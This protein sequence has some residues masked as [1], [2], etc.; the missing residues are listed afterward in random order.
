MDLSKWTE[1]FS[2]FWGPSKRWNRGFSWIEYDKT[3]YFFS[4]LWSHSIV[5]WSYRKLWFYVFSDGDFKFLKFPKMKKFHLWFA[6]QKWRGIEYWP[7]FEGPQKV[8]KS[9]CLFREIHA[10]RLG[11]LVREA[12]NFRGEN[13]VETV[14]DTFKFLMLRFPAVNYPSPG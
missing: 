8:E 3:W 6:V 13:T 4:F 7:S 14:E 10:V 5:P 12:I 2:T 1:W 9:V 11:Y